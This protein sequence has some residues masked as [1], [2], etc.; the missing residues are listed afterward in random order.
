MVDIIS[1]QARTKR[2]KHATVTKPAKPDGHVEVKLT[3]GV[4][5]FVMCRD[6]FNL[7][8]RDGGYG[9]IR[10]RKSLLRKFD[11]SKD[12]HLSLTRVEAD[13]LVAGFEDV[14]AHAEFCGY[15]AYERTPTI[16]MLAKLNHRLMYGDWPAPKQRQPKART[17]AGHS[18]AVADEAEAIVH[19][20]V[21]DA[22]ACLRRKGGYEIPVGWKPSVKISWNQNRRHCRGGCARKGLHNDGA[23]SMVLNRHVPADGT[24]RMV[25]FEEYRHIAKDPCIGDTILTGWRDKL[26]TVVLHEVAH[27]VQYMLYFRRPGWSAPTQAKQALNWR[28]AHGEGWQAVYRILRHHLINPRAIKETSVTPVRKAA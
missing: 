3:P 16:R 18:A 9:G 28:R 22:V 21:K 1:K 7:D 27:A 26:R 10:G 17:P 15:P 4:V 6:Y 11:E 19:Q 8:D 25:E 12:F 24:E 5:G 23:I 2:G 14:L 13:A 20:A